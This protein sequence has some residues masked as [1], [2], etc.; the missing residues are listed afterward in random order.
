MIMG[1]NSGVRTFSG[2]VCC[3]EGFNVAR[4]V[5]MDTSRYLNESL[6]LQ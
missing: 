1:I 4:I 2:N 6:V 3:E 5:D